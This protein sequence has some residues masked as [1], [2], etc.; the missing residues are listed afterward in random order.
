METFFVKI[1]SIRLRPH[2]Y[3]CQRTDSIRIRDTI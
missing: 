1:V 2:F 3:E